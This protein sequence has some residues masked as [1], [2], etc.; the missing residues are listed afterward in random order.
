MKD[1]EEVLVFPAEYMKELPLLPGYDTDPYSYQ[2]FN[3]R[4]LPITMYK[5]RGD[6]EDNPHFKQVIPYMVVRWR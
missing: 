2:K 1:D 4:I 3:D 6:V 5:R